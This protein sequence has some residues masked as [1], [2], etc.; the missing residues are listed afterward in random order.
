MIIFNFRIHIIIGFF[1]GLYFHS[2]EFITLA[3]LGSLLPDL[4]HHGSTLGRYNP[5]AKFMMHRGFSH[6]I[7]GCAL[8]S[9][10][11][12]MIGHGTFMPVFAG[13]VS[14]VFG[15]FISSLLKGR[16]FRVRLW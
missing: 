3:M 6:S 5:F 2:L 9:S 12:A 7:L 14:H 4:D 8:L 13:A 11:F 10:P 1:V 16:W 15:D